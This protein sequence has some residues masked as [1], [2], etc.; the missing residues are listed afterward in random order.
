MSFNLIHIWQHMGLLSKLIAGFIVLMGV[1]SVGVFVERLWTLAKS[2]RQSR[3][4]AM[5]ANPLLTGWNLVEI[6]LLA[7]TYKTSALARLFESGIRAYHTDTRGLSPVERARRAIERSSEA[8]GAELRRGMNVLATV[9]SIAPFVGLLGTVVGII[10]AFQGIATTGSGGL[11]AVSAGIAEALVE[12]ALGLLVAIPA[13]FA[14]NYLN[15]RITKTEQALARSAGELLD[16]MENEHEHSG[17]K[18]IAKKAA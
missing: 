13:V 2:A 10:T 5:K 8:L 12:T 17:L 1:A 15:A 16:E 11:G 14:F 6:E 4:F 7:N 18:T 9:G 3:D